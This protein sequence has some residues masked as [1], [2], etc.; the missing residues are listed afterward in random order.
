MA[1]RELRLI[2]AAA[3]LHTVGEARI[4]L[5]AA[6]MEIRLAGVAHRPAADAIVEIEQAGLVGDFRAWACGHKATWR[7]GRDRRLLIAGTLTQKAAGP[8]RDDSR[9]GCSGCS[10]AGRLCFGGW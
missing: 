7:R 3:M 6:E 5:L 2:G 4:H 10:I 9:L 1:A 8:N